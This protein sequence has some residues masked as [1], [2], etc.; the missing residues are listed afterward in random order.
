MGAIIYPRGA[1]FFILMS[2]YFLAL[3][4]I[5]ELRISRIILG[6]TGLKCFAILRQQDRGDGEK[7]EE[8]VLRQHVDNRF[9]GYLQRDGDA[10]AEALTQLSRRA[11]PTKSAND[12]RLHSLLADYVAALTR[13][14]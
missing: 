8:I 6:P 7:H 3:H 10:T 11:R 14:A 13:R 12:Q 2:T 5:R 1:A 9:I 4:R